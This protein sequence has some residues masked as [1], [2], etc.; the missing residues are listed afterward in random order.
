M[1]RLITMAIPVLPGQEDNFQKFIKELKDNRY[2]EF[3]ASRRKLGVRERAFYQKTP[4]GSLVIVT[5][6]GEEPEK[7][8]QNFAKGSDAFTKWFVEQVKKVHNLDLNAPPPGP[9]PS[10]MVD[11]GPITEN[12]KTKAV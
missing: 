6:E 4:S 9:M 5:L 12:I 8:F 3:Q 11:S 7:A 10:L 1:S 2:E